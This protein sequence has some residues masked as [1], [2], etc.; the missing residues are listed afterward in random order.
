VTLV[1]GDSQTLGKQIFDQGYTLSAVIANEFGEAAN[2]KL[3]AGAL[4]AAGLVLFV[5]TLVINAAAR[6]LVRRA[7]R[8]GLA[9]PGGNRPPPT[10][11]TASATGVAA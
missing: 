10:A 7:E 3:H 11:G 8:N 1:I 2:D 5:L 4:I 6:A 9:R